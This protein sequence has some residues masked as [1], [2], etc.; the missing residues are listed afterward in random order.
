MIPGGLIKKSAYSEVTES[1]LFLELESFSGSFIDLKKDLFPDFS[2]KWVKDPLHQWSRQ[3]EYPFT[4][5]AL[6]NCCP[7]SGRI[8]DAGSGITFFPYYLKEKYPE[9]AIECCDT[10]HRLEE[11]FARVNGELEQQ[12]EYFDSDIRYIDRPEGFYDAVYCI[13]V[14]EH[15]K[16]YGSI[17]EEL[18]RITKPGGILVLTFDIS[19]DGSADIPFHTAVDLLSEVRRHYDQIPEKYDIEHKDLE[20]EE[21]LTTGYIA[22]TDKKLLPWR[23]PYLMIFKTIAS[24]KIPK[25]FIRNL[26]CYCG[27]FKKK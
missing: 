12:V 8:L 16:D 7:K 4:A 26:S 27:I 13:S 11:Q 1:R 25:N 3:Y 15:T 23:Y 5:E 19:T 9:L 18:A 10:D 14:L 22:S 21:L 2:K 20:S 17:I 6:E 24:G